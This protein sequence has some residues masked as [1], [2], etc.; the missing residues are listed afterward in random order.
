MGWPMKLWFACLA[1]L[2]AWLIHLFASFTLSAYA[3]EGHEWILHL[4][5]WS[6]ALLALAG[7]W[8][9]YVSWQYFKQLVP[10]AKGKEFLSISALLIGVLFFL[11]IAMSEFSNFYLESCL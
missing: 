11:T 3:C 8:E 6:L 9:A 5:S 1:P 2:M 4:L 10:G 7:V